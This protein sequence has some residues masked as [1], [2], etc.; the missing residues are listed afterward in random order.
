MQTIGSCHI[1]L[2]ETFHPLFPVPR[3]LFPVTCPL[4]LRYTASAHR[5]TRIDW[6]RMTVKTPV[7][8]HSLIVKC[9]R[10]DR[11]VSLVQQMLD[12]H[13]QRD[14]ARTDQDCKHFQRLIDATDHQI[15]HLVYEFY[16]LTDEE[17]AIVEGDV[18]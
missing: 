11:M 14:A 9:E 7:D 2:S 5:C 17:S 13:Q 6:A 16:D 15:D 12:L 1:R 18:G 3:N 8:L 10:P 4:I